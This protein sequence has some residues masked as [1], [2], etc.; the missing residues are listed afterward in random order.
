LTFEHLWQL[1]DA[2]LESGFFKYQ[3]I[4]NQYI[5]TCPHAGAPF[6]TPTT[7]QSAQDYP[8]EYLTSIITLGLKMMRLT[9]LFFHADGGGGEQGSS[10][11]N[12]KEGPVRPGTYLKI[13]IAHGPA[14]GA[15]VGFIRSFYCIYGDTMN[16]AARMS[17]LAKREHIHSTAVVIQLLRQHRLV[18]GDIVS[19]DIVPNN[20]MASCTSSST[21]PNTSTTY[22]AGSSA[23]CASACTCTLHIMGR[24]QILVK[25]KGLMRTFDLAAWASGSC[26]SG[27]ASQCKQAQSRCNVLHMLKVQHQAPSPPAPLSNG[28][29]ID[30]TDL[31]SWHDLSAIGRK[32]FTSG[33]FH[34][35]TNLISCCFRETEVEASFLR[36]Y[37]QNNLQDFMIFLVF[38]CTTV[39]Y[40]YFM[41]VWAQQD[42]DLAQLGEPLLQ[43][44]KVQAFA[45]LTV[46]L[47]LLYILS[48]LLLIYLSVYDSNH[49]SYF[50]RIMNH[51][52]RT[53]DLLHPRSVH[54]MGKSKLAIMSL[55]VPALRLLW[56]VISW[57][58]GVPYSLLTYSK[59]LLKYIRSVFDM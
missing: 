16:T 45:L 51:V 30:D 43:A 29:S 13:G 19:D 4:G 40:Q 17:M 3:H 58:T 31:V 49:D 53:R 18:S 14:A 21:Q 9:E 41:I 50:F 2:V 36:A 25:G 54:S 38:H 47:L 34:I 22:S 55:C 8:I 5:V 23:S 37:A 33:R 20:H 48:I 11:I 27:P 12:S 59:F 35:H 52:A 57:Y 46:H 26:H 42:F 1:D 10:S 32:K 6:S 56:I 39:G 28:W 24:G 7:R 15:V 44:R